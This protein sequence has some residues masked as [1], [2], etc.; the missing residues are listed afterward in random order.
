MV[1]R[2]SAHRCRGGLLRL[3]VRR[4]RGA[5]LDTG[6]LG[7]ARSGQVGELSL[8]EALVH[9]ALDDQRGEFL[10]DIGRPSLGRCSLRPTW[11]VSVGGSMRAMIVC[12]SGP[13]ARSATSSIGRHGGPRPVDVGRIERQVPDR[14]LPLREGPPAN[15][16]RGLPSISPREETRQNRS[17]KASRL[18]AR[19]LFSGP[20]DGSLGRVDR[21]VGRREH[22]VANGDPKGDSRISPANATSESPSGLSSRQTEPESVLFAPVGGWATTR[23]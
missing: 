11:P 22:L 21:L 19:A 10:A 4:I 16:S 3:V 9:T 2:R 20:G 14:P 13:G 12:P 1:A 8:A 17:T 18:V 5:A 15:G 23:G 7:V 6:D